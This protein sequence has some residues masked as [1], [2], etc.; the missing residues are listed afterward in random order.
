MTAYIGAFSNM[1]SSSTAVFKALAIESNRDVSDKLGTAKRSAETYVC[2]ARLY[3]VVRVTTRTS[4]FAGERNARLIS[5]MSSATF[6]PVGTCDSQTANCKASKMPC[7]VSTACS[8]WCVSVSLL[9]M[10]VTTDIISASYHTKASSGKM[11]VRSMPLLICGRSGTILPISA[12]VSLGVKSVCNLNARHSV[13]MFSIAWSM[14]FFAS[15]MDKQMRSQGLRYHICVDK[16]CCRTTRAFFLFT[17]FF[18]S[19]H[20]VGWHVRSY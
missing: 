14:S 2:K 13:I 7:S 11:P 20:G 4:P 9:S 10:R 17:N 19:R 8:T 6:T 3:F 18:V 16:N 5:S 15:D 1:P 12:T